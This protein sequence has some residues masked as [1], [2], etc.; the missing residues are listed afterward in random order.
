MGANLV[1]GGPYD[2]MKDLL[3]Y[4]KGQKFR[5]NPG[6]R[7]WWAPKDL[8]TP[9]KLKNLQ[10]KINEVNGVSEEVA[11]PEDKAE[12][13]KEAVK[14]LFEK[15]LAMKLTGIRFIGKGR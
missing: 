6:D 9:Q 10:K 13:R 8:L 2:K 12:A 1:V 3:T 5:Y 14:G 11:E 4:L 15:A 7:T